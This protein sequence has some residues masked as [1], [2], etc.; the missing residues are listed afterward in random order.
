MARNFHFR[1]PALG[2]LTLPP[3]VE[4]ELRASARRPLFYWLRGLLALAAGLQGYELLD[5][6]VMAPPPAPGL[7]VMLAPAGPITTGATGRR[8][9]AWPPPARGL[10]VAA[11]AKP[12]TTGAIVLHQMSWLLFLATLLMGLVSADSITRERHEGTLGL[13][14][15][16]T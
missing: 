7:V 3:L 6:F 10:M 13:L 16:T 9:T 12:I 1:L 14:L 2:R 5:R 8:Q 15:L 4:L 11:P